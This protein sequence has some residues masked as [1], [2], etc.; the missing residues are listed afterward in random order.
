MTRND[1]SIA[2]WK[3]GNPGKTVASRTQEGTNKGL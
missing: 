1:K 3:V 2:D